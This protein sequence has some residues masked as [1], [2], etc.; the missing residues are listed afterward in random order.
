[1]FCTFTLSHPA[2]CVQCHFRSSLLHAFP[3]SYSDISWMALRWFQFTQLL[4]VSFVFTFHMRCICTVSF[5]Y[6]RIFFVFFL[7]HIS[8]SR[9]CS[10]CEHAYSLS[11]SRIMMS[12]LLLAM[13]LSVRT[14]SFHNM[15]ILPSR[16]V[17][18][19]FGRWLFDIIIVIIIIIIIILVF[20]LMQGIYNYIAEMK[21]LFLGYTVLQLCCIYS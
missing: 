5:L 19:N 11:L 1:M 8:V 12:G 14:C 20:T 21:T 17:S 3:L 18:T 13:V 10:V 16:F 6:F 7:N 2:V 4:L 9:N 15:V